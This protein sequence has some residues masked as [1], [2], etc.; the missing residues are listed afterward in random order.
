MNRTIEREQTRDDP[1]KGSVSGPPST[2]PL[3]ILVAL[4]LFGLGLLSEAVNY[5]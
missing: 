3:F 2:P 4:L 5:R 1:N